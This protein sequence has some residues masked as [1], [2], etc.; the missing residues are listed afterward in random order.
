MHKKS[1]H[2]DLWLVDPNSIEKVT[3]LAKLVKK[4][5]SLNLQGDE[6]II[7]ANINNRGDYI[8][9]SDS[10]KNTLYKYSVLTNELK[11]LVIN[12]KFRKNP[13]RFLFFTDKDLIV[14]VTLLGKVLIYNINN[15]NVEKEITLNSM[16][17]LILNC[18]L[19]QTG[20]FLCLTT[21]ENQIIVADL[22][23][24]EINRS[25]P[26]P[27]SFVNQLKFLNNNTIIIIDENN[28]FYLIN[29]KESQFHAFTRDN[30]EKVFWN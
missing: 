24:G 11:K 21:I 3:Y 17:S 30:F 12:E 25:L 22:I 13:S 10:S 15:D 23:S 6:L 28:K 7:S 14:S 29:I 2:L 16:K 9:F 18:D 1:T 19:N 20:S 5:F 27:N 26:H 8:V 4:V